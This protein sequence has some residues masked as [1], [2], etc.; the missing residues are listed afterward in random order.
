MKKTSKKKKNKPAIP[1]SPTSTLVKRRFDKGVVAT[2]VFMRII[3]EAMTLLRKDKQGDPLVMT[4]LLDVFRTSN[5]VL[6]EFFLVKPETI[7]KIGEKLNMEY[8]NKKR[9]ELVKN[10]TRKVIV[11]GDRAFDVFGT[12]QAIKTQI[13]EKI[14]ARGH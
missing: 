9:D 12:T 3:S 10:L 14:K 5:K 1:T 2:V 8:I 6:L 13:D 4:H 7:V 11:P